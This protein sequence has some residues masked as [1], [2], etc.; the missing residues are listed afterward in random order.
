MLYADGCDVDYD[1][2]NPDATIKI[3][4]FKEKVYISYQYFNGNENV[5]LCDRTLE[6][7][8]Q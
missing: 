6:A 2:G 8:K 3:T 5:T 1:T 7:K 4:P